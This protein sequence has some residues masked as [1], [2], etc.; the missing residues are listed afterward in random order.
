M[1]FN[2]ILPALILLSAV[3]DD[4]RSQK[5]HNILILILLGVALIFYF[6][7]SGTF[8]VFSRFS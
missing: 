4:L 6:Y 2:I 8:G 5:I 7:F 1:F 3:V